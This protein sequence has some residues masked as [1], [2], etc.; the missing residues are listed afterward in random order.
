MYKKI[1]TLF[2]GMLTAAMLSNFAGAQ[3]KPLGLFTGQAEVGPVKLKGDVQFDVQSKQYIISGSGADV[4]FTRDELHYV[5]KKIKGD[6][7]LRANGAF[8]GADTH[9]Y[10]KF[11]LM[12]RQSLD[13]DAAQV[14]AVV[15]G[16]KLT[17]LQYRRTAG[18]STYEQRTDV[19]T[20]EVLQL[21]RKGNTYIMRVSRKGQPLGAEKKIELN[22]GDEVYVGL[23]ICSHVPD[24]I[25]KAVF[26]NVRLIAPAMRKLR[27]NVAE[28]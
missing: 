3:T 15:H 22:L 7:T 13:S 25:K 1:T 10:G 19:E 4:F 20:A 11:G 12:V 24:K 21:Q 28:R 9:I 26:S 27:P 5:F 16:N 8:I 23:F 17:A 18:D 6:F 2:V 14:N